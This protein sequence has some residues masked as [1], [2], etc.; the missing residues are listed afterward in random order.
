M[1]ALILFVEMFAFCFLTFPSSSQLRSYY[2]HLYQKRVIVVFVFEVLCCVEQ[3][4]SQSLSLIS[5]LLMHIISYNANLIPEQNNP[6]YKSFNRVALILFVK[7]LGSSL[8]SFSASA[9]ASQ[10]LERRTTSSSLRTPSSEAKA[11]YFVLLLQ[12][13]VN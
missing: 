9:R 7:M 1:T 3:G 10:Q 12:L 11:K 5:Q 4:N 8:R 6:F 13:F 2:L